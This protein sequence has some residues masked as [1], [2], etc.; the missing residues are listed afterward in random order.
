MWF[1]PDQIQRYQFFFLYQIFL[2]IFNPQNELP[3]HTITTTSAVDTKQTKAVE[4]NLLHHLFVNNGILSV[5][6]VISINAV[7]ML[8][9]P[10]LI[11]STT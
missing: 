10:N 6:K 9:L 4:A 8:Y 11:T 2:K 3:T 1:K 5:E 7:K